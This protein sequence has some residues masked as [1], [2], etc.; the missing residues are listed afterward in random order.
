VDYPLWR[1][2]VSLPATSDFVASEVHL[3]RGG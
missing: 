2:I 1:R 3:R